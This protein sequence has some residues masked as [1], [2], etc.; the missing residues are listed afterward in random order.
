MKRKGEIAW[1]PGR[2]ESGRKEN[3]AREANSRRDLDCNL[4]NN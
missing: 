4:P 3:R 2:R 1:D